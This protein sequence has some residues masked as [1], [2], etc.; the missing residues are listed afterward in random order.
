[1][2]Y[3]CPSE[4]SRLKETKLRFRLR[5]WF[6]CSIVCGIFFLFGFSGCHGGHKLVVS[7]RYTQYQIAGWFWYF[8]GIES[9]AFNDVPLREDQKKKVIYKTLYCCGRAYK[10]CYE[11]C[12]QIR[13]FVRFCAHGACNIVKLNT[14]CITIIVCPK[15]WYH[16]RRAM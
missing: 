15:I 13:L 5:R 3:W 2:R 6:K 10:S 9:V 14:P 11:V 8:S 16:Q 4:S 1:M 7:K 12:K